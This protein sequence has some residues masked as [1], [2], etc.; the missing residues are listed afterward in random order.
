[1]KTAKLAVPNSA[2]RQARERAGWTQEEVAEQ[3]GTSPFT[4]YRWERGLVMPSAY[5][6]RKLCA[7]YDA[8]PTDLGWGKQTDERPTE[9][10]PF[11]LPPLFTPVP[12]ALPLAAGLVGR[13]TSLA[14]LRA[15]IT[16]PN[17]PAV[18]LRGLP[19][20][21]KT[22]LAAALAADPLVRGHFSDGILWA[23]LGT[24]PSLTPILIGWGTALGITPEALAQ[25]RSISQLAQAVHAA[26][27]AKKVLLFLDDAWTLEDALAL[28]VGGPA[29]THVL[30]TRFAPLATQFAQTQVLI[31]EE[32]EEAESLALLSRLVPEMMERE[33]AGARTLVKSV[34]GLPLALTLLGHFLQVQFASGQPR[35]VWLVLERLRQ[36]AARLQVAEPTA[37]PEHPLYLSPHTPLSLQ[38]A[39]MAS[40]QPLNKTTQMVLCDLALFPPKP[41]TFTEEAAFAACGLPAEIFVEQLDLLLDAGLVASVAPE[42]YTIHQ[43]IVD[44]VRLDGL[45]K[46]A[47]KRLAEYY[48]AFVQDHQQDFVRL[49]QE[50]ENVLA[51]LDYAHEQSMKAALLHMVEGLVPFWQTRGMYEVALIHLRRAEAVAR[52]QAR[53]Q[54][55]TILLRHLGYT[56]KNAGDYVQ[57]EAVGQEA[58]RL[59][60][61]NHQATLLADVLQLLG[62]L[63]FLQG[64]YTKAEATFQEGLA[65][66]RQNQHQGR[67]GDCLISLA[68]LATH[69]G[70]LS[71][72]EELLQ[73]ALEVA[74][75]LQNQTM[76]GRCLENLG[77]IAANCGEYRRAQPY[78][79]ETLELMRRGWNRKRLC[80]ILHNVGE[81]AL[82]Q[83]EFSLAEG[84]LQEGL[85]IAREIGHPPEICTT[86]ASLGRLALEEGKIDQATA[87]L[88]DALARAVALGNPELQCEIEKV[89]AR[90][91]LTTGEMEQAVAK[92]QASVQLARGMDFRWHIGES[93][94]VLGEVYLAQGR[95][96]AAEAAFQE[97][98][99][100]AQMI[101][102][103]DIQAAVW[104]GRA[105]GVL[106]Q[107]QLDQARRYGEHSRAAF[108]QCGHFMA[109]K[110][111][112]WMEAL[113]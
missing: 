46:A 93:L 4:V 108:E 3:I 23:G 52:T 103:R 11:P 28:K 106:E 48:Q 112:H 104:Y 55:L 92:A 2:L 63:D 5:F 72:A 101:N 43:T 70:D 16:T 73:Q 33:A 79:E 59:A 105:R 27:G 76:L 30:T 40:I 107:G 65:L 99:E 38:S 77:V 100:V 62:S 82:V 17:G 109:E 24:K 13:D 14:T 102:S 96:E 60:R 44:A 34:G 81:V 88:Q 87:C 83:G 51:V 86:L 113:P 10:P 58:L 91:A 37:P 26:I 90:V 75:R 18:A 29:C 89:L 22:A 66:A 42:R 47:L 15:W 45:P 31:V 8:Q 21:G 94:V 57:A 7:L 36:A 39:I 84:Y 6:R 110:V 12:P 69:R 32:L 49:D 61:Q 53:T 50:S 71:L 80:H 68:S 1:M 41:A 85:A 98:G 35:R 20:V 56:L 74:R 97:A 95:R 78:F 19:G 54:T 9:Q 111:R 67:V 25:L 64:E